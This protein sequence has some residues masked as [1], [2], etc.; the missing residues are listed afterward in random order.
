M[1][2]VTVDTPT[3]HQNYEFG[4][5]GCVKFVG[6]V[7]GARGQPISGAIVGPGPGVDGNQFA[8][9]YASTDFA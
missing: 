8:T 9:E 6:A 1:R 5:F 7:S 3:C 4:N 2:P